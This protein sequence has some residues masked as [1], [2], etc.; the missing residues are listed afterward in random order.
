MA[1]KSVKISIV[2]PEPDHI[3]LLNTAPVE[4]NPIMFRAV[5]TQDSADKPGMSK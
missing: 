5:V 3:F 4:T 2:S 1:N